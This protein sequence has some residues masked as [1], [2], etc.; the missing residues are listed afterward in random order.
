MRTDRTKFSRPMSNVPIF[1]RLWLSIKEAH[2]KYLCIVH[3]QAGAF[4]DQTEEQKRALDRNSLAY[5]QDLVARGILLH[6]EALQSPDRAAIVKVRNGA[7]SMTDGPFSEAKEQIAGFILIEA[8]DMA[9]AIEIAGGIPMAGIGTIEV[10]PI[11]D[12]P[13]P[14]R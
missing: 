9:Q 11:Y 10:R 3:C 13:D 14:D 5:D 7:M 12:I 4:D 8:R 1:V 6:A 2:M